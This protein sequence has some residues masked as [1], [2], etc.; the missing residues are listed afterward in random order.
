MIENVIEYYEGIKIA[1]SVQ[2][3]YVYLDNEMKECIRK[4]E[5]TKTR[6]IANYQKLGNYQ[7]IQQ[8]VVQTH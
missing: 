3:R 5:K 1:K 6:V 4:L 7:N 2:D 8:N